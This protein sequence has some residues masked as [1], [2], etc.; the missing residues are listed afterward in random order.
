MIAEEDELASSQR[1]I[2]YVIRCQKQ[3]MSPQAYPKMVPDKHSNKPGIDAV[4]IF[5]LAIA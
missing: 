4:Y 5:D 2:H 1:C 3:A